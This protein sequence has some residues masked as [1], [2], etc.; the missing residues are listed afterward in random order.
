MPVE[1]AGIRLIP[2]L[3]CTC[4]RRG[5]SDTCEFVDAGGDDLGAGRRLWSG[6]EAF[7]S[8]IDGLE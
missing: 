7:D 1:R 8:S 5:V 4:T 2:A 3:A 6:R